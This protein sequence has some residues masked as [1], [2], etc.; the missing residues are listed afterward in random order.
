MQQ[1]HESELV[2]QVSPGA[3]ELCAISKAQA[4]PAH[5]VFHAGA[6]VA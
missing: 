1:Q 6:G 5:Q 4:V 2:L 3:A